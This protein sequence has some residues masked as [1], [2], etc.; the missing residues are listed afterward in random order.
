MPVL[1]DFIWLFSSVLTPFLSFLE[2]T[3]PQTPVATAH[4]LCLS[5]HILLHSFFPFFQEKEMIK[6]CSLFVNFVTWDQLAMRFTTIIIAVIIGL[7]CWKMLAQLIYLH[8]SIHKAREPTITHAIEWDNSQINYNT[9]FL[10]GLWR[11]INS[12]ALHIYLSCQ[13]LKVSIQEFI[14]SK[15]VLSKIVTWYLITDRS[16]P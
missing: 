6:F 5:T 2:E 7:G 16:W 8:S 3:C 9:W 14:Y 1:L 4:W 10:H 15:I 13:P 12:V 11:L